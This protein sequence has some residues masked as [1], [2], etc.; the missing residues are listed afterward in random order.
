MKR[1]ISVVVFVFWGTIAAGGAPVTDSP[2]V[3]RPK[4]VVSVSHPKSDAVVSRPVTSVSVARPHTEVSVTH[5]TTSVSVSHP[6][7]EVSVSHPA[8]PG[9][10]A[11]NVSGTVSANAKAS[12]SGTKRATAGNGSSARAAGGSNPSPLPPA[13][14][15]KAA[16]LGAGE[17]GLGNKFDDA[18]KAAAAASFTPPKAED[19][20][21]ESVLKGPGGAVSSKITKALEE[22]TK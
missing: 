8:S 7:T 21:M 14:D 13:K 9:A 18:E 4:T 6:V 11:R 12:D 3:S 16:A 5:P 15:L 22:Q 19:A 20:S 17:A 10:S 2:S 1:N